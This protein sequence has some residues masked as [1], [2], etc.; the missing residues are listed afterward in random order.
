MKHQE[1]KDNISKIMTSE[2]KDSEKSKG[3]MLLAEVYSKSSNMSLGLAKNEVLSLS[4]RYNKV[5]GLKSP[6]GGSNL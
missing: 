4:K 1:L 3:L 2:F 5:K 6:T